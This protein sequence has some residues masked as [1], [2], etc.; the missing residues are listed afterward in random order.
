MLVG[1]NRDRIRPAGTEGGEPQVPVEAR[2]VRRVN[3]RR[4][5]GVLRLKAKRIDQPSLTIG[6]APE[7]NLVTAAGDFS[8]KAITIRHTALFYRRDG[9]GRE[10]D[11]RC[12]HPK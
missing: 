2:L 7:L 3:A 1:A 9:R 12:G 10:M 11:S 4:L 6:G 8:E 5:G